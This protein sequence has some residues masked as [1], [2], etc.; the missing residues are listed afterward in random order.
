MR[1]VRMADAFMVLMV[2]SGYYKLNQFAGICPIEV[3]MDTVCTVRNHTL[4]EISVP[5]RFNRKGRCE[6][7]EGCRVAGTE[8]LIIYCDSCMICLKPYIYED[9]NSVQV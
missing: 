3:K 4:M 9:L 7:A 2:G 6:G 5:C 8:L 1:T